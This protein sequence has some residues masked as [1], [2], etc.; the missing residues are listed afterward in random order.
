M[1]VIKGGKFN[2]VDEYMVPEDVDFSTGNIRAS[3]TV[4]IR[5]QIQSG[6]LVQAGKDVEVGGDVWE[7]VV[8]SKGDVR[9]RGAITSGSRVSGRNINARFI[10]DSWVDAEGDLDVNLSITSSEVYVQGEAHRA[11]LARNHHRG[12]A[13]QQRD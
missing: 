5:G 7:A 2:I 11:R 8:E 13:T 6:F 3:G 12:M 4:R 9:V 1:I 10:S